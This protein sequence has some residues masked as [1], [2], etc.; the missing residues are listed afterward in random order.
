MI[1][2]LRKGKKRQSPIFSALRKI[3]LK[4]VQSAEEEEPVPFE[5]NTI[6]VDTS[7][8]GPS[9]P[10][11]LEVSEPEVE[12][13]PYPISSLQMRE[14]PAFDKARAEDLA[15]LFENSFVSIH[16]GT[17]LMGSTEYEV[18]RDSGEVLHEVTL[19]KGF[20]MQKTP[21]IQ[22]QW[23]AVMGTNP[24]KFTEGGDDCPVENVT[25]HDCLKFIKTLNRKSDVVYRLPTEA[26]WEY[27]C[28]SGSVESSAE[29]MIM[30]LFCGYDPSLDAVGWY[31]GNSDRRT[32]PVALKNANEWGL[33]DM[34]GNVFEWCQDWYGSYS[35]AKSID[36]L[37]LWPGSGRVIRG[38]SWFANAKNCRSAA[39]LYWSPQSKSDF[40]GFRL[41]KE[42]V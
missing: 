25:W 6:P 11:I 42:A 29:G 35:P 1:R 14:E 21:V 9:P 13:S 33:Y 32:H 7:V 26:E 24:S 2:I 10:G 22:A 39:R 36:S 30:E 27:A 8:T 16:P 12:D 28:R 19:T 18:G 41:V 34:H 5:T 17:F 23:R 20:Y 37:M 3:E 31:C 4:S 15:S 40:I 38:G